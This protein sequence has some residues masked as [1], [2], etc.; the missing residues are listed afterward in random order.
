MTDGQLVIVVLLAFLVYE[1]LWWVPSRGWLF[2][3]GFTGAWSGRRPWSLFGRKGG[4]IAEIRGMGVHMVAAGW[5]CVPHEH[6]LCLWEDEGGT[7]LHIPWDQVKARADGAVLY[8]APGHRV[9][10]IHATSAS[11][12]A[13]L[14]HAWTTQAHSEREASFLKQAG[15]LLDGSALKEAAEA[16]HKLTK[17]LSIQG[18]TILI[19]TFL[20]VP[21]TYWRYGDHLITLIVVAL[22][23][24]HMFIQAFL[25]FRLVRRYQALR[26]DAFAHVLGTT[27]L[28]G[29]SIRAGSWVCS[30]L[31]PEAHP[32]AALL[33]WRGK[34]DAELLHHAKRC[35]REARWPIGNFPVRPWNGPEV[36]ALRAFLSAHEETKPAGL[37]SPPAAQEGCT[38]WCPRCLT[39]YNDAS[40]ECSDCAGMT[41]LP[42]RREE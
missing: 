1:S 29:T 38:Q 32:L 33:E 5:P 23:F 36:E 2:Q 3:R 39:Q 31:S 19:W 10:C 15:A 27:M 12:W 35:W 24:L 16:N 26:K 28:P 8:L 22:L 25:L 40:K 6:G 9:R 18:G 42:L 17:H 34:A 4:G 11:A 37:E 13:K 7:A 21:L 14:V 41:L 30:Q 20:V